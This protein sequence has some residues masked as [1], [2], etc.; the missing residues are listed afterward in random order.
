MRLDARRLK[1]S[2]DLKKDVGELLS[3]RMFQQIE[4]RQADPKQIWYVFADYRHYCANFT[5]FLEIIMSRTDSLIAKQPLIENLWEESGSGDGSKSHVAILETFLA[6]WGRAIGM[7][8]NE[9]LE[10]KPSPVVTSFV[11][12]ILIYLKTAPLPAAFGFVGPGTEEITSQQY[13]VF[14][15]G[16]RSY[17]LVGENELAFFSTHIDA[18][19]KHADVFWSALDQVAATES[20]WLAVAQ[21][22]RES[23]KRE[24]QFWNEMAGSK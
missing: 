15:E 2:A 19:I 11:D 10:I 16:L 24:T 20:D 4:N 6:S 5:K 3:S 9:I 7:S 14:L 8:S 1:L 23:I 17:Q 13:S 22:A 21:G 18:D 12:E